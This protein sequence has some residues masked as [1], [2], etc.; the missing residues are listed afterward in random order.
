[1][2]TYYEKV[3]LDAQKLQATVLTYNKKVLAS[4]D[5][6]ID[7]SPEEYKIGLISQL[8]GKIEK[9]GV[10][11]YFFKEKMKVKRHEINALKSIG[12]QDEW[13][14]LDLENLLLEYVWKNKETL[15]EGFGKC[16]W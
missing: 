14:V 5:P 2:V 1:L 13:E 10:Y 3:A 11:E 6:D 8:Q 12:A 4:S 7:L 16:V 15:I 9:Y